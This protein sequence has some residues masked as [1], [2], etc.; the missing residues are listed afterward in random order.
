VQHDA[1]IV[2]TP[3]GPLVAVAMTYAPSGVS[4]G[5]SV[6]YAAQLLRVA[7]RDL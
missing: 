3:Q 4:Y 5:G 1:A 6:T 2:F 7:A